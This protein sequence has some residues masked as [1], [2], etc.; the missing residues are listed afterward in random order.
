MKK[1]IV[2]ICNCNLFDVKYWFN[3][4]EKNVHGSKECMILIGR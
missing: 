2:I 1:K 4:E 3:V